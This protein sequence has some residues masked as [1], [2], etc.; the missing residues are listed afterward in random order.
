MPRISL[1]LAGVLVT[2]L[3]LGVGVVAGATGS[4]GVRQIDALD[5]CDPAR[6]RPPAE[7]SSTR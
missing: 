2:A 7:P 6:P 3:A 4:A 1:R 5:A